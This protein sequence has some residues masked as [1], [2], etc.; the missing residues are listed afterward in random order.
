[1]HNTSYSEVGDEYSTWLPFNF[2][3]WQEE[4]TTDAPPFAHHDYN[5]LYL[6]HSC[7]PP[8]VIAPMDALDPAAPQ[9]VSFMPHIPSRELI[10]LFWCCSS[11]TYLILKLSLTPLT[12]ST[13]LNSRQ[14][15][16]QGH[17]Q[18]RAHFR[19]T[20]LEPWRAP[21][22][23]L[24]ATKMEWPGGIAWNAITTAILERNAC[25][26]TSRIAWA[27]N[28]ILVTEVVRLIIGMNPSH[29]IHLADFGG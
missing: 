12:P 2:T 27:I 19:G 22:K 26:I 21:L 16:G 25:A 20:Q 17:N 11:I 7:P 10:H 23:P 4:P 5:A 13:P 29:L 18:T 1:M 28:S 8:Y 9:S 3:Q 15:L 6:T 14:C 24:C